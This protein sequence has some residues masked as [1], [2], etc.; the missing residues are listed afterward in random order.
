MGIILVQ[1]SLVEV[2]VSTFDALWPVFIYT[3][4][5]LNLKHRSTKQSTMYHDSIMI[6]IYTAASTCMAAE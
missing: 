1:W 5:V 4:I 3:A 6:Q 2:A